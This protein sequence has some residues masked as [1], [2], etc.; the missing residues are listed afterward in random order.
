MATASIK[1]LSTYVLPL[2]QDPG[3]TSGLTSPLSG[4]LDAGGFKIVNLGPG[5][6]P[7]DSIEFSQSVTNPLSAD[8]DAGGFEI[9]N[10]HF[11]TTDDSLVTRAYGD[12]NYL[13]SGDFRKDGTV[14]MTGN[15]NGGTHLLTHI[16]DG[17]AAD[18]AVTVGQAVTN[19][20]NQ[21]VQAG[22]FQLKGLADGTDP[23]DAVT[24]T[25]LTTGFVV[26]PMVDDLDMGT[27]AILNVGGGLGFTLDANNNAW[28]GAS[29]ISSAATDNMAVGPLAL[30]SVASG[31]GNMAAGQNALGNV[32][33]GSGNVAL[34]PAAGLTETS[35][36]NNTFLG[37][38]ADT[39]LVS[40]SNST[41]I[42]HAAVVSKSNQVVIGDG[43]ITETLI[44]SGTIKL[45]SGLEIQSDAS[46]GFIAGKSNVLP[47]GGSVRNVGIGE[48]VLVA[49]TTGDNNFA[50]GQAAGAHITTAS[51]CIALGAGSLTLGTSGVNVAIGQNSLGGTT[52]GAANI[53]IGTSALVNNTTGS[54]G[55]A[56]GATAGSGHTSGTTCTY[57]GNGSGTS[58]GSATNSTAVGAGAFVTASNQ[59]K[60]GNGSVT[61]IVTASPILTMNSVA[62]GPP[63][64]ELSTTASDGL[65]YT[66]AFTDPIGVLWVAFVGG[67]AQLPAD[68]TVV[69][70]NLVLNAGIIAP[71]TP[72]TALYV[73]A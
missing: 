55:T 39:S 63:A 4:N 32:D 13:G 66:F 69:G 65:T 8:L 18:D 44:S 16:A 10:A 17:I 5:S 60:L 34:G 40:A 2:G 72:V 9:L 33:T 41:A 51:N 30:F 47:P 14:A 64:Y 46:G 23:Q 21:D 11:P 31:A 56:I 12:A 26:N 38:A 48:G 70:G 27:H 22:G 43:N 59:I 29:S 71:T 7:A 36:D 62:F 37:K 67:V 61:N 20:F 49:L 52:T 53:A 15:F 50:V 28:I 42:G 68:C 25:Q 54:S 6:A 73:K 24:V 3:V 45:S 19:P 58:L 1:K 57:L 35:G